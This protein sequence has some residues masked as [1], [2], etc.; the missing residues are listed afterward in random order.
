MIR[1]TK[2]RSSS[3]RIAKQEV[4]ESRFIPYAYHWNDSTIVT[5]E[6]WMIKVIRLGGYSFE[7]ADDDDVDAHKTIRNQILKS[8]ATGSFGLYFHLLRRK[9]DIF[10][11][12]F[13]SRY[14]NNYFIDY[15][16]EQW[17]EKQQV[18]KGFKNELYITLVKQTDSIANMGGI[19]NMFKKGSQ[20][21]NWEANLKESHGEL[22]EATNRILTGLRDYEPTL[23]GTKRTKHGAFSSLL[24]F[25]SKIINFNDAD[26][27]LVNNL[28]IDKYLP[29]N[30]LLFQRKTITINKPEEKLYGGIISLK[31]YPMQTSANMLDSFLQMPYE[32]T[33]TQ[34]F[35]FINRQVAINK[36]QIQQNR[37]IQSE[38]KAV[39][40]IAEISK[41][42]DDA[43]SGRVGFGSHHLTIFCAEKTLKSIEH[44]LSMADIELTNS[45]AF[46]VREKTN[47]EPAFWAQLPGNFSYIVRKSTIN[48]LNMASLASLHNY[49]MGSKFNNHWGE[50]VTV[51]NTTSGTPFF[52][53]FHVRD[54][55]HTTIIGPTG[56]GKTVLM[57]FL[58]SQTIKYRPRMFLFDKDRGLEIFTRAIGGIYTIIETRKKSGFNPLQLDDTPDNRTFLLEWLESMALSSGE[59]LTPQDKI[60]LSDAIE[61]NYRLKKEDRRLSNIASFLGLDGEGTIAEKLS[62]WHGAGS[63]HT[64][65]DNEKDSLDLKTS[66]IFGF[67]MGQIMKD[68]AALGPVLLYIFHRISISLDGSPAMIVLDEAWALI[69]NPIFAPKIKEWLKVLRKLN[70][71]VIFATQS[72]EDASNSA[73]S[74]TL[75]QQTATQIFLPN[76]KATEVYMD[77]FMLSRREYSLIK[78]TDPSTRYFLIKQGVSAVV[79]RLDLGGM[80]DAISVL[81]GRTD[82]ILMLDDIRKETGDNPADWLPVFFRRAQGNE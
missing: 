33:L 59:K 23:L 74:E 29:L 76:L 5:K 3:D 19:L 39:S 15:L 53:N 50:A 26:A 30:R 61:G 21:Q 9:Y 73:I 66:H 45:G 20:K 52:F 1:L 56:A 51:F 12:D 18:N 69:D 79:A 16:A 40:Q 2:S 47:M 4:S 34:S 37:M 32:F 55:G 67:E 13:G 62:I 75:I 71:F 22:E 64:L 14:T 78:T 17:R 8:M 38:D 24:G 77:A 11:G 54:V 58:C 65:F 57:G 46:A 41:S 49:P 81:S 42:L 43:T 31:E 7:T 48:T 63:H 44:A 72:V 70:T 25:L 82:T 36:M 60:V 10:S 6:N 27:L 80:D 28:R 35:Q 68:K